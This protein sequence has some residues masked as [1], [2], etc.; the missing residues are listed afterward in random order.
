MNVR[1]GS[2]GTREL[3]LE[4]LGTVL[5]ME[6]ENSGLDISSVHTNNNCPAGDAQVLVSD[7]ERQELHQELWQSGRSVSLSPESV[8]CSSSRVLVAQYLYIQRASHL[9]PTLST[10]VSLA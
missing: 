2:Y 1:A 3:E 8:V 6:V 10:L 5:D 7:L 4:L 9:P